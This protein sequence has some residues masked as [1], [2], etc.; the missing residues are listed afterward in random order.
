MKYL[1]R[2]RK[3]E[4]TFMMHNALWSMTKEAHSA[5]EVR[6]PFFIRKIWAEDQLVKATYDQEA[7]TKTESTKNIK[8]KNNLEICT[9]LYNLKRENFLQ[10]CSRIRMK[11][12]VEVRDFMSELR[13][14]KLKQAADEQ[15][16]LKEKRR[17][18]EQQ[19]RQSEIEERLQK[20]RERAE[21][22]IKEEY[23]QQLNKVNFRQELV[24]QMKQNEVKQVHKKEEIQKDH[25]EIL[26]IVEECK[27]DE[28]EEEQ[29]K[30]NER[31]ECG[32]QIRKMIE[33]NVLVKAHERHKEI[34]LGKQ[35]LKHLGERETGRKK[36]YDTKKIKYVYLRAIGER[37]GQ[38]VHKIEMEKVQ[39]NEFLYNLHA[40]EMKVKEERKVQEG[41]KNDMLKALS[42]REGIERIMLEKT[43]DQQKDKRIEEK[44]ISEYKST[45]AQCLKAQDEQNRKNMLKRLEYSDDLR[46][47]ID[48]RQIQ[49]AEIAYQNKLEHDHR[50]ELERQRLD[51]VARERLMLLNVE[52]KDIFKYLSNNV[53]TNE[54]RKLFK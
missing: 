23:Q 37:I 1:Q 29:R 52:L 13:N 41:R 48:L 46:R 28:I 33:D 42:F 24:A 20:S 9:E 32:R 18:K 49:K 47:M 53:L 14:A 11:S 19:L 27:R 50:M 5:K 22:V 44:E 12:H 38:N 2:F 16:V 34:E 6:S 26:K 54:E 4:E 51:N 10:E 21:S 39:R 31:N 17:E 43:A 36:K 8:K 3:G 7:L 40:E 30:Q 35:Y 45:F 15:R 25:E